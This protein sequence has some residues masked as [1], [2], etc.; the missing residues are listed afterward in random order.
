MTTAPARPASSPATSSGPLP[1]D[2]IELR[3]KERFLAVG[4]TESGKSTLLDTLGAAFL[5][6]YAARK[7]RRLILD[8]KPRYRAQWTAHRTP[9]ARRYRGWDHGPVIPNSVVVDDPAELDLAWKTGASTVI[10]QCESRRDLPRLLAAADAF[11]RSSRAGR[12]QVLQVDETGDFYHSNGSPRDGNDVLERAARAGRERGT[13]CLFGNQRTKGM[14]EPIMSQITKIACFRLDAAGDVKRLHEM[15]MP[16]FVMPLRPHVFVY[17]T[18]AA[19]TD[20]WGPFRLTI[21]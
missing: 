8:S 19:Y 21:P 5:I 14:A 9:A 20:V 7:P 12:P 13:A 3:H 2:R 11:L 15:G 10:V 6:R 4:G 16:R 18:K 1:L 17:W